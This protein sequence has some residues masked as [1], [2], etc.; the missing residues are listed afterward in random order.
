MLFVEQT[1]QQY[2]L[3]IHADTILQCHHIR[4]H[5]LDKTL[6]AIAI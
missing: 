5:K 3:A 6:R 2:E 4:N 1:H